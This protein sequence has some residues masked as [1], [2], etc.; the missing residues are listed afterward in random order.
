M[1]KKI[2]DMK[3]LMKE[4]EKSLSPEDKKLLDAVTK[5]QNDCVELLK[6]QFVQQFHDVGDEL[7]DLVERCNEKPYNGVSGGCE[8]AKLISEIIN[9]YLNTQPIRPVL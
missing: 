8:H 2:D 4:I 6:S 1:S 9:E 7:Y 3:E 5:I